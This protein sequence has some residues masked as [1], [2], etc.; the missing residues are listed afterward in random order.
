MKEI[1]ILIVDDLP[2]HIK[3]F[4]DILLKEDP[5]FKIYAASNGKSAFDLAKIKLPHL[6]I[7]D[8]DMPVMNGLEATK[9][10]KS[11]STTRDI[12]IIIAS[13]LHTN[14]E[15]LKDAMQ[16]G[17]V[18]FLRKPID[19]IE[20][21]ARVRSMLRFVESYQELIMEK[22]K[23]FRQE[24]D[25][26][27]KELNV[28][29]LSIAKQNEFLN[30]LTGQ[31]KGIQEI[32]NAPSKK[33]IF[34]LIQKANDQLN[35]NAWENFEQQFSMVYSDFYKILNTRFPNL[36]A[37]ERKLCSLLKMNL[38]SKE[39]ANLTFQEPSSVDVARYRLRQKLGLDK[40]ENLTSFIMTLV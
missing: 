20:L 8:W 30:Y 14:S 15:A 10:L 25:F 36:T 17:A 7:M 24:L 27:I 11:E 4:T 19:R 6:I 3:V 28:Y 32:C 5:G 22:E 16:T 37:S 1:R 40:D 21:I 35:E 38:S 23:N 34:P 26:R 13:G 31:L 9:S 2:E 39:I 12:P 29:A 33:M 18:D